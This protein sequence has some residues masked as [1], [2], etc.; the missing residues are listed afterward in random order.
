M[1][2]P[3]PQQIQKALE[4]NLGN[5]A[6]AARD[7]GIPR[8]TLWSILKRQN[9]VAVQKIDEPQVIRDLRKAESR[10]ESLQRGLSAETQRRKVAESDLADIASHHQILA[11][12]DEREVVGCKI[13]ELKF[14]AN[15]G[16]TALICATDWHLEKNIE[17]STVSGLNEFNLQIA[18]RRIERLWQKSALLIDA[19]SQLAIVDEVI[20]WL[21]GDLV[22]G[23]LRQEDLEG[24]FL[25]P[26]EAI[27]EVERHVSSGIDFL[28]Q[29]YPL[30]RVVTNYGNHS[31]TTKKCHPATGWKTNWEWLAFQHLAGQHQNLQ[32]TV[33]KGDM[34]YIDVQGKVVRLQH[35]QNVNYWGGVGGLT[36]PLSKAIMSWD[37]SKRADLSLNGH[38]HQYID[39]GN[40]V[41]CGCL[42][43][44]DAFAQSIKAEFQ[45]PTQT[46]VFIDHCRGKVASL[47]VFVEASCDA[48]R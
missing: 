11:E 46:I 45:P 37:K 43:G 27:L 28:C 9:K 48:K 36:I 20:L 31:R 19:W 5:K 35:G 44:Y 42:C 18:E 29:K 14:T 3:T 15:T 16:C 10:I 12:L 6:E 39:C 34:N 40:F 25:G 24:N 17:P 2:Q 1:S 41:S 4:K 32:W 30:R 8:S 26:T 23:H 38:F 21:G 7:L 22:N 33:P 47:P 13:E